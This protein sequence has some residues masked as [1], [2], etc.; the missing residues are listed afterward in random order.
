M[1]LT[2][3]ALAAGGAADA[4]RGADADADA[5]A[6]DAAA[7]PAGR[8]TAADR[9][10][11]ALVDL[12]VAG[13]ATALS[14]GFLSAAQSSGE[15]AAGIAA[16]LGL[17]LRRRWPWLS[18]LA[19]LPAFYLSIAYVPLVIALF[20]LGLSRAPRWQVAV[21]A[22]GSVVAYMAPLW[23]PEDVPFLVEPLVDATIY[24][25]GPALLG[26][27]LRE[28]RTARA[29]LVELRAAQSLGQRQAAEV[30]LSRE[31]AVL[32]REMHDVVS[33]QVSL[34]AVQAG[35]MQVGAADERS[36]EAARTIRG[37]STVTLEELRGMVE[38]LRAAGGERRELAP[39]PTLE[40]VPA[41]VAAS[42][43]RVETALDLPG[44]LPAAAQ[45]AVYRTVQEGLT[46]ARK[47][48]T[49]AAVRITGRLDAGH[50][51]LEVDAG[52]PTLPLLDLPSGRH[53][54]TG[55]RERAQLLGGTLTAET[56]ADGSHLLRL[57]F[58]L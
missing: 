57:R 56:R 32:A 55:L 18:V 12:L 33:H 5:D 35:A 25:V 20:D 40:D 28:R 38:V 14:Y 2:R 13:V 47:H 30:A 11:A 22:V 54:L 8:P 15:V 46:N 6:L 48:A 3:R 29:Q 50:V 45:R 23:P 42:G 7:D 27:F 16:C 31:R 26:A 1:R 41:L 10:R 4:D 44:D 51:V 37:L 21:A 34:I 39:Q 52:A 49:G 19:A 36:R 43:I 17:V 53:G 24:T 9:V 58:P